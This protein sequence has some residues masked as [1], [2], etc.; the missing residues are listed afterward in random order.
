MD[1]PK[2]IKADTGN[3]PNSFFDPMPVVKVEF[4]NGETKEL[5]SYYPDEIRF[6]ESELI[7][8]TEKEA[9]ELRHKKDVNYLRS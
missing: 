9:R 4:D 6:S 5:F 1:E 3:M 7:G 8:L 2:I